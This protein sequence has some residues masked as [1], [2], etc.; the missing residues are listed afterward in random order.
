MTVVLIACGSGKEEPSE[1]ETSI[2]GVKVYEEF[3]PNGRL[4][5]SVEA[6]GKLRHGVSKT[7]RSDG[8]LE[9]EIH[10][11]QNRKHGPAINYYNDG[12]TKK[13]EITYQQGF[14]HGMT[15]WYYPDGK[16]YRS[17]PYVNGKIEGT[18]KLYYENGN[19]QAEIPYK[20]G[21]PGKGLKEYTQDGRLK[22]YNVRIQIRELDRISL[23]KT[24][25]LRLSLSDGSKSAEFYTGTLTG[26][27]FWNDA[28]KRIPDQDGT[29]VLSFRI[30]RGQFKM[31]TLNI[32]A[33]DR[34]SLKNYQILTTQ[35]HLAVE[36]KF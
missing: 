25:Q 20:A 1:P 3:H 4:K 11:R 16:I 21:Q 9:S 14:K 23:D 18:R 6:M 26:G 19:L 27:E 15:H 13:T 32:V 35:Y 7:F 30:E 29:G 31:E 33:R 24:F 36:N 2:P 12:S 8:T 34:T 22:D 28:L 17:T 10:Y 5:S